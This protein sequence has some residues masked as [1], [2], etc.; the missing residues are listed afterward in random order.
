MRKG[1][2]RTLTGAGICGLI[3]ST[4]AYAFEFEVGEV[5]AALDSTIGM[6]FGNRL[7]NQNPGITGEGNEAQWSAGDDG[8]RNYKKGDFYTA[9]IKGSHELLLNIPD[10]WKGFTRGVWKY[11]FKAGDTTFQSENKMV[12]LKLGTK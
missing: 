5:R 1:I 8:N 2:C 6:G 3:I 11:D 9:Y 4:P 7:L 10:G 12:V